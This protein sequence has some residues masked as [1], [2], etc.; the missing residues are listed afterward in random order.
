MTLRLPYYILLAAAGSA[1]LYFFG[2]SHIISLSTPTASSTPSVAELP[3]PKKDIGP[4]PHLANPPAVIKAIYSTGWSAGSATKLAALIKLVTDTEL[5]A[6]VIDAKDFSGNLSYKTE[7]PLVNKYGATEVKIA[8]PNAAIKKL[9][10]SGIYAIARITVFQ[11]PALAKARPDLALQNAATKKTW[12]DQKGLMWMDPASQE[13]W[14]YDIA[15]AKDALERGFDEV[16]FDYIRFPTDGDTGNLAYPFWDGITPRQEI[17]RRFF[18]HMRQQLPDAKI[19]A[20]IFG[21]SVVDNG[22]IG[23]GQHFEN[24]LPYFDYVSPM[25]YPSHFADGAFGYQKPASHPYEI[26]KQSMSKALARMTTA[27]ASTTAAVKPRATLRPWFQD[28]DYK[29]VY[30]ATMVRDQ[31]RALGDVASSS[32][33]LVNGWF[34]WDPSNAYTKDAL[35]P[36]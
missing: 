31:I 7:L 11:D 30:T 9:H 17:L 26:I 13:V 22:D 21:Q 16:N 35:L 6:I 1:L 33:E 25:V 28:F 36:K 12:K 29:A 3:D 23:I 14:D 34:L 27:R 8:K 19:S 18:E 5:N 15:I 32:P 4:Q 20:D 24:F 2:P 10:D